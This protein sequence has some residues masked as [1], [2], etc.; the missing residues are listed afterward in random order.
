MT[1]WWRVALVLSGLGLVPLGCGSGNATRTGGRTATTARAAPPTTQSSGEVAA[2]PTPAPSGYS[3]VVAGHQGN[4]FV[5]L[6]KQCDIEPCVSPG[7]PVPNRF[8]RKEPSPVYEPD[9]RTITGYE[10]PGRG[11]VP[12]GV[13][14]ANVP[15]FLTRCYGSGGEIPCSTTPPLSDVAKSR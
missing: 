1:S 11:F 7:S 14:P 4:N 12:V 10:Y 15:T 2:H 3:S 6:V 13:D 9:L 8:R 5:G